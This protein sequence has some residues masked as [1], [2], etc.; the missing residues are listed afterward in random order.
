L[1]LNILKFFYKSKSFCKKQNYYYYDNDYFFNFVKMLEIKNLKIW[2]GEKEILKWVDLKFELWKNYLLLWKNGSWKTSLVNFLMWNPNY[3]YVDW[4]IEMFW[5]DISSVSPDERSKAGLFLSFQNIPE[6]EGI[7]LW[8]YLRII[9]NIHLKKQNPD[10]KDISPFIFKRF[11]KKYLEEL[12]IPEEFL[13]RDLNV[14]FSWGEKRKIELLQ[15]KLVEPKYIILDEID[16][17]LDLDAFKVVANIL[18]TMSNKENTFIIITHQFRILDY[19]DV[20]K[21]FVIED[22]KIVKEWGEELVKII[23]EKGF[24]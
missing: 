20:D 13:D 23:D 4:T 22:W 5:K 19:I 1:S 16:S 12:V 18:K 21:I 17:W 15:M 2:V 10:S 3:E 24:E 7:K 11:V 9:Y 6:I 8:E 14:G